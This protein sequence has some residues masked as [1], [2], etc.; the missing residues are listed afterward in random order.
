MPIEVIWLDIGTDRIIR[1]EFFDR[2]RHEARY[3]YDD[4]SLLLSLSQNL[5]Y[6]S[7]KWNIKIPRKIDA[8]FDRILFFEY[9]IHNPA[10]CRLSICPCHRDYLKISWQKLIRKIKFRY[11]LSGLVYRMMGWNPWGRY[12]CLI[13]IKCSESITIILDLVGN[14]LVFTESC[15]RSSHL[16]LSKNK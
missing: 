8:F 6:R 14:S 1:S 16:S 4:N 10:C 7:R 12:N 5:E 2:I 3:L 11:H 15:D 9:I 13:L